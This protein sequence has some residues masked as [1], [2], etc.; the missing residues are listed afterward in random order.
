MALLSPEEWKRYWDLGNVTT[1]ERSFED[2]YDGSILE[3]WEHQIDGQ[4]TPV[5]DLCCGNGALVWAA[6]K[7]LKSRGADVLVTGIDIANIKPFV[8]LK[9]NKRAY[10][11]VDFIGNTSIEKLPLPDGSVGL[12][13]SQYGLEYARFESVIPELSRVLKQQA[14]IALIMHSEQ[15][16]ILQNMSLFFETF[17]KF[18]LQDGL[19][20]KFQALDELFNA[21]R[22]I[23][24][25]RA[26]DVYKKL[27][28]EINRILYPITG[29][30]ID[31]FTVFPAQPPA[32]LMDLY[33]RNLF[34]VFQN[35]GANNR[36]RKKDLDFQLRQIDATLGRVE[37]LRTAAVSD[38]ELVQ[39]KSL[40]ERHGFT[41]THC[42][43]LLYGPAKDNFGYSLVAER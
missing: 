6:D 36:A 7:L 17:S 3:F 26:D 12:A 15:S 13:I 27:M 16:S 34:Q 1:F 8:K 24:S 5:I 37:D 42:E 43:D 32:N 20:E 21:H 39:L 9:R 40:L 23:D 38:Q 35:R 22:T 33:V 19:A 28:G 30:Y 41:V 4:H 2:G 18:M 29:K 10:P 25:V 14:R 31:A 11:N